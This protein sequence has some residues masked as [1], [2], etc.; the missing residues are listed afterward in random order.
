[1]KQQGAQ[2]LSLDIHLFPCL[3]DNYGVL[4]HDP[5]SGITASID[6]PDA[7]DVR[8]ALEEKGWKLTHILV[9][10]HH[11]DHV[12]GILELKAETGCRVIGP[13]GEATK[14][15]GIDQTVAEGDKFTLGSAEVDVIETP[16]HTL[17]HITYVIPSAKVAFAGDTL[18]ALG[19]GRIFEG[20]PEM[21]HA[22]LRKLAALPGDTAVYCGHEYTLS[23]GKFALRIEP[24]NAALQMRMKEIESLRAAGKPTLPTTIAA[25]LATNPFLR[26]HVPAI[27]ERLGMTGAPDWQVFAEIRERKN[28]G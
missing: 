22:S 27:K 11:H 23:N 4:V 14:I 28:K 16:G 8:D 19:C 20:T 25:E 26:A 2:A 13:K 1:M 9:T 7:D 21:M 15:P 24:E 5:A 10:H 18:F 6:A 17:G 12:G 3:D